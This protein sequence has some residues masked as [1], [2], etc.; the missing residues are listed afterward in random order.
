MHK[1]I[2]TIQD[3]LTHKQVLLDVFK[4][5]SDKISSSD[6]QFLEKSVYC[7]ISNFIKSELNDRATNTETN[8]GL[9]GINRCIRD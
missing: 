5:C 4:L 2:D 1:P 6:I 7:H 9:S 3:L 8:P